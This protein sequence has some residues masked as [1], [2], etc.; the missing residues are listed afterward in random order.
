MTNTPSCFDQQPDAGAVRVCAVTAVNHKRASTEPLHQV[1][2][3]GLARHGVMR[4]VPNKPEA[5][6][7]A[8]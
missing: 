8:S 1:P 5:I 3:E 6:F 4:N 2:I 7:A